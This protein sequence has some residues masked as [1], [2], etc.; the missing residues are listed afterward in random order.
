MK[1]R[2]H[3]V[4]ALV[5]LAQDACKNIEV[6]KGINDLRDKLAQG[7]TDPGIGSRCLGKCVFEH[8]TEGGGRV[9]VKDKGGD[10]SIEILAKSGKGKHNQDAVFKIVRQRYLKNNN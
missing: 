6:Q 7:F 10:T 9:Y 5:R 8:R 1:H 2:I 4:P 3:E